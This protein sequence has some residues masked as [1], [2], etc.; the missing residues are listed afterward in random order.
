MS[1]EFSK[2]EVAVY[3]LASPDFV[4]APSDRGCD[5]YPL[6]SDHNTKLPAMHLTIGSTH[7]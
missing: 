3:F 2:T 7:L 5:P 1:T 4:S 6:L